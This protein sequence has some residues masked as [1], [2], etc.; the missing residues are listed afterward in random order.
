MYVCMYVCMYAGVYVLSPASKLDT[1]NLSLLW[2][3]A[4]L[5]L[6]LGEHRRALEAFEQLLKVKP[7]RRAKEHKFNVISPPQVLPPTADQDYVEVTKEMARV[8]TYSHTYIH[9]TSTSLSLLPLHSS[10]SPAPPQPTGHTSCN[11]PVA[12]CTEV[13]PLPHGR[14]GYQSSC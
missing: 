12:G 2:Q 13:S 8:G 10:P 4:S 1:G 9:L 7:Q 6:Q 5:H 14:R 3:R 11:C